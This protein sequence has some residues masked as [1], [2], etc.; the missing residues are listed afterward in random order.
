MAPTELAKAKGESQTETGEVAAD[1]KRDG[2]R[3]KG[4]LIGQAN[5]PCL[6]RG[7]SY[8]P[9]ERLGR[10][11]SSTTD[12]TNSNA[13]NTSSNRNGGSSSGSSDRIKQHQRQQ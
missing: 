1:L 10:A 2:A 4:A 8:S 9:R 7:D 6:R 13:I 12:N 3:P 5:V 11:N